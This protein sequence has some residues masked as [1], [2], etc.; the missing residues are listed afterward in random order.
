[1]SIRAHYKTV[2][3]AQS[4]PTARFEY[5]PI[6]RNFHAIELASSRCHI[7]DFFHITFV[8]CLNLY[9]HQNKHT[10]DWNNELLQPVKESENEWKGKK[11]T[12]NVKTETTNWA[13]NQVIID[14]RANEPYHR[15]LLPVSFEISL[16][17]HRPFEY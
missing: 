14:F 15:V 16:Q 5:R 12:W 4:M 7:F 2:K 6:A 9:A 3:W 17:Y 8:Q 11:I 10:H 13:A 1:M